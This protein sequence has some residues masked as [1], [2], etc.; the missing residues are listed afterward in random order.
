[1]YRTK[2]SMIKRITYEEGSKLIDQLTDDPDSPGINI[3]YEMFLWKEG[4]KWIAM[5]NQD[6]YAWVEEFEN[7]HDAE[8]WLVN[9]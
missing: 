7:Q 3:P 1:M 8:R 5:D 2:K 9:W 6:A 4:D